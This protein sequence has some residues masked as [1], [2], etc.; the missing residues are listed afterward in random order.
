M[1]LYYVRGHPESV[2][3][4]VTMYSCIPVY[5]MKTS[6]VWI[7]NNSSVTGCDRQASLNVQT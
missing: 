2:L 7:I 6:L 1:K 4:L 5:E 3:K